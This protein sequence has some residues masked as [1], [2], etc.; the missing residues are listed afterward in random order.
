MSRSNN[1]SQGQD[2]YPYAATQFELTR[3]AE[4]LGASPPSVDATVTAMKELCH[5]LIIR[6]GVALSTNE[7][8]QALQLPRSLTLRQTPLGA[9]PHEAWRDLSHRVVLPSAGLLI[10][11]VLAGVRLPSQSAV[12]R[13]TEVIGALRAQQQAHTP[14]PNDLGNR[15][16]K[17]NIRQAVEALQTSTDSPTLLINVARQLTLFHELGSSWTLIS[18]AERAFLERTAQPSSTSTH[19][20]QP[21]RG[22]FE[23]LGLVWKWK[24]SREAWEPAFPGSSFKH[25]TL[26]DFSRK[27]FQQVIGSNTSKEWSREKRAV[28]IPFLE[29]LCEAR[30][31][32]EITRHQGFNPERVLRRRQTEALRAFLRKIGD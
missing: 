6:H 12:A 21:A 1:S 5:K 28:L 31:H 32:F 19:P 30:K 10:F 8:V 23:E 24:E 18:A 25:S 16:S 29:A 22:R 27:Y 11:D 2:V 7:L 3:F 4:A 20:P 9:E 17:E 14:I 15:F 13:M 26:F